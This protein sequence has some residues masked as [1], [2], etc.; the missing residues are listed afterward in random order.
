MNNSKIIVLL[1]VLCLLY[2]SEATSSLL[3]ERSPPTNGRP[4][5]Y[6]KTIWKNSKDTGFMWTDKKPYKYGILNFEDGLCAEKVPVDSVKETDTKPLVI[7]AMEK[8]GYQINEKSGDVNVIGVRLT[9]PLG[10]C[11]G[12]KTNKCWKTVFTNRF[13]DKMHIIWKC[14]NGKWR[15]YQTDFTTLP[16]WDLDKKGGSLSSVMAP[17]QYTNSYCLGDHKGTPAMR[18]CARVKQWL[19]Q[20]HGVK[21]TASVVYKLQNTKPSVKPH[22]LNFH[23]TINGRS[24]P[25]QNKGKF[26][27]TKLVN[28][29][30]HGCQ[31]TFGSIF[32][33]EVLP[34]IGTSMNDEKLADVHL[35]NPKTST[36]VKHRADCKKCTTYT[37]LNL[38]DVKEAKNEKGN[39]DEKEEV[40]TEEKKEDEE[41]EKTD[42]AVEEEKSGD[43][44]EKEKKDD[45]YNENT[46]KRN[47]ICEDSVNADINSAI[48]TLCST[49]QKFCEPR[50]NKRDS[51]IDWVYCLSSG[52]R[53]AAAMKSLKDSDDE[54]PSPC[55]I[56]KGKSY[57]F[58][59]EVRH[60]KKIANDPA[61]RC[62]LT[63]GFKGK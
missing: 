5:R 57:S 36:C 6:G 38:A 9:D 20:R 35:V 45:G 47:S 53:K 62:L 25:K 14:D 10:V 34:L 40:V 8:K 54:L 21:G 39:N 30:S 48:F 26:P 49:K 42:D 22:S 12:S 23:G 55:K 46:N 24:K 59:T 44:E 3:R 61:V 19:L 33:D 13:Q 27:F 18:Q 58:T 1:T 60:Y 56:E 28:S 29:W 32:R 16:G 7:K 31:V 17:G 50:K 43:D 11:Q 41:E 52:D 63:K 15:H 4:Q 37:L 51:L 2:T